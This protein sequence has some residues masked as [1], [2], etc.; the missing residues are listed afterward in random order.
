MLTQLF[1]RLRRLGVKIGF[2][3]DWYLIIVAG[4]IGLV[5]GTVAVAFIT[6]LH[7]RY[8]RVYLVGL[9]WG[10]KLAVAHALEHTGDADGLVL[11][12]PGLVAIVDLSGLDK[13]GVLLGT[14]CCPH[15]LYKT[16]I[17][18]ELFTT[19]PFFLDGIRRDP[20]K[21]H[22]ATTRFF[23]QSHR[24]DGLVER[25]MPENR[26]PILLVLAGQ[27]RIIDNDGVRNLL[28]RGGGE[29]IMEV[30]VYEDQTHSIQFDAPARLVDDIV[31]W[32]ESVR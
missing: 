19:T 28:E 26:L 11:I 27:D 1:Q 3:R 2:E 32:I 20:L 15:G 22:Y 31:L 10:G 18:P 9:S 30:V 5:M 7:E 12:T 6:P 21:L 13:I 4:L 14:V 23:F 8:D 29:Q 25:R 17:E 24:L 16:P